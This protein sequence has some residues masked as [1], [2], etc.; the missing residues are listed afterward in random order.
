VNVASSIFLQADRH[1]QELGA[2]QEASLLDAGDRFP[3]VEDLTPSQQRIILEAVVTQF[4]QHNLC[5]RELLGAQS[6]LIFPSLI[7]QKRP[8]AEPFESVDD[9]AYIVRG[10]VESIYA[11][12]VVLLGYTPTFTRINQWQNQ[13]QY[14]MGKDEICGFRLIE[15]REGEIELVLYYSTSMPSYGRLKFRGIF[16]EI[17]YKRDVSVTPFPPVACPSGHLQQ[18]A[19]VMGE[20]RDG[21]RSMYCAKCGQK[22]DLPTPGQSASSAIENLTWIITEEAQARLRTAYAASLVRVKS[23][24]RDR[25]NPR[26]YLSHVPQDVAR[27]AGLKRDLGEAGVC[28]ISARDQVTDDDAIVM[29]DTPAYQS[30][31]RADSHPDAG[32]I[33]SRL[34][35][36]PT[37]PSGLLAFSEV[38]DSGQPS[39]YL[40]DLF[41]LALKL[42]GLPLDHP[43]FEPL[44]RSLAQQW[45]Q[46]VGATE[47]HPKADAPASVQ[48]SI[49]SFGRE[50]HAMME[51]YTDFDLHI[52]PNG[53]L[54]A[55]SREGQATADVA[56]K[57]PKLVGMAVKLIERGETDGELLKNL[58]DT[59]YQ[60]LLPHPIHTHLHQTEAIARAN[61]AKLR[62]RLRVE[63]DEIARLPLEFLYRTAGDYFMAINPN[64]V[65]SRYLNLPL[66]PG[67][68]RQ[69]DG[70]LHLLAIIADPTDQTRLDPDAW[71]AVLR[72]ALA[73]P[74]GEGRMSMHMVKDA[75]R[76]EIRGALLHK[77]PDIIQFVG[78]GV[79]QDGKG[80]LALV[81]EVTGQTWLVDDERFANLFLG[82][83]D[84]LGLISLATCESAKSDA[85][86]G[87]LGV[88]PRLVQRGIPAVIAMQ[89]SVLITTAQ[90]FMEDMYTAVAA[91]KPLDWAV[92][93]ARN[94]ISQVLGMEN[95]E[96][97]TPVLYMR[98][99]DGCIF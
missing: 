56:V 81:E 97:A 58:G 72:Q 37:P 90:I 24:R 25:A 30:A 31:Y 79:Y 19:V 65:L 53:H 9:M 95:R 28:I 93:S 2:L 83:D 75:T 61:N 77:K 41:D 67:R 12:L 45:N 85:P 84:T 38:D 3:E 74:L 18:R 66:P 91:R 49:S 60:W 27:V 20:V 34:A 69:H 82:Y 14:E 71:E 40:L 15:D 59:L 47:R 96:F 42:Y 50:G 87:F 57:P 23:A 92:Q 78:H 29:V 44:R 33:R 98:A 63:A 26:C 10:K 32:L 1:P 62:I 64:T 21:S 70:P 7:K 11:S 76:K 4:L 54:V 51:E 5:F 48:V 55:I 46:T 22:V 52:A 36:G 99:P 8:I 80:S 16:E 68:V 43:G 39:R 88:A 94:A 13:A 35:R 17:L 89:Y 73:V 6:L 86:Q